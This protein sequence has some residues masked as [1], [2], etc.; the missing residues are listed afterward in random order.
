MKGVVT[1]IAF[2]LIAS[3]A[4]ATQAAPSPEMD[5][6]L[7]AFAMVAGAAFLARARGRRR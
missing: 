3:P 6:G 4:M 5:I 7:A 2:F 1:S